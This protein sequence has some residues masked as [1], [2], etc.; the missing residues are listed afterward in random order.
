[1][2]EAS[3]HVP[4]GG[5]TEGPIQIGPISSFHVRTG[6]LAV[7]LVDLLPTRVLGVQTQGIWKLSPCLS[8][9][10]LKAPHEEDLPEGLQ[11]LI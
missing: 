2:Q 6:I 1:M 7:G 3:P 8:L 10:S 11:S 9:K 4:L 5:S